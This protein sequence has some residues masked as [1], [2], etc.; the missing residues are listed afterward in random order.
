MSKNVFRA[1][2]KRHYRVR[3]A[4][5]VGLWRKKCVINR[6]GINV[7]EI[8]SIYLPFCIISSIQRFKRIYHE[9]DCD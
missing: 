5:L 3:F 8:I 1:V 2:D 6:D 4:L 9:T 7:V